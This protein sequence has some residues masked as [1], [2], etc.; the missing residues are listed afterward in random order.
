MES[1]PFRDPRAFRLL[2]GLRVS[3]TRGLSHTPVIRLVSLQTFPRQRRT[4]LTLQ[5]EPLTL[6]ES[7]DPLIRMSLSSNPV[8][9]SQRVTL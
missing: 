4:H 6:Y 1:D 5:P 3:V 9:L 2:K 7:R 8:M